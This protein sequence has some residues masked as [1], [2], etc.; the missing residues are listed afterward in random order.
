[1]I[2]FDAYEQEDVDK[3]KGYDFIICN[4]M[5]LR[6]SAEERDALQRL[7]SKGVPIIMHASTDSRNEMCSMDSIHCATISAYLSAGNMVNYQNMASYVRKYI[8]RK[9]FR[10]TDPEPP[11]ESI[12]EVFF[13]LEEGV[14]FFTIDEYDAYTRKKGLYKEGAKRVALVIGLHNPFRGNKQHLDSIIVSMRNAGHNVYPIFAKDKRLE[15]LKSANPDAVIYTAMGRLSMGEGD[16]VVEWLKETN[17]PLFTPLTSLELEEDWMAN[18]MG[19]V[20]GILGQGVVMPEIDGAVYPYALIAQEKNREGFYLFKTIPDRLR[21]FTDIVSRTIALKSKKNSEKK[22]AIYFFKGAGQQTLLAQSLETIPSLHN[23]L[24]R[25]RA[26]GYKVENL[27]ETPEELGRMLMSQGVILDPYAEGVQQEFLQKGN[28]ALIKKS[29]YEEW[30]KSSIFPEKY[31]EVTDLY[32][33]APGSYMS[34]EADGEPAIAVARLD[35]GNVALLPQPMAAVGDDAFAIVHGAK[36]PPPHPYIASYLWM[37]HGFKADAVLHFGTHG[38]LEF[39]PEK[40]VALSSADWS[41]RLIGSVPHFYYYTIAN[42]GECII[43]KRR[44]YAAITSYLMPP[45]MESNTRG[46]LADLQGKI[47]A[48]FKSPDPKDKASIAVKESAM[49]LGIHRYLRLDSIPAKPYTQEEIE[50]IDN[51]AEE[52][53]NE[54]V[55]GEL[56]ITGVPYSKEKVLTTVMA[57]SADPIAYSIARIDRLSGKVDTEKLRSNVYF[58]E[59]YLAPAKSVVRQ[60]LSGRA[61]DSL[62]VSSV[63]GV[64]PAEIREAHTLLAPPKRAMGGGR[65]PKEVRQH[66]K[67]EREKAFAIV[68]A[69]RTLYDVTKYK[70][71]LEESPEAELKGVLNALAGGYN[72]PS[73]GG[74]AIANPSA[75]PTGRN[76]Y[77]VNAEATPTEKAWEDGISLVNATLARY[78]KQHGDYPRKVSF[79]FWSGEFIE[80]EGTTIAQAL[81][82]LGVEPVRDSHGRVTDLRLI[83]ASELGRP[84]IDIVVQ[85]SGQFR[86]LAASRLMYI[87]RAVEM[88]AEA[89]DEGYE[90]KVKSSSVEVERLLVEQ[91]V[92][93]QEARELSTKRV[94]GGLNGMYGTKIKE[95]IASSDRW[96]SDEEIANAYINNMGAMYGTE[97]EWGAFNEHLFRAVLH[98]ADLVVQPRQNNTWGALSLDHVYEFMGGINAAIRSV[99]GKDPDAVFAD[100]RNRNNIRIQELKEAIGVEARATILNPNFVKETLKGGASSAQGVLDVVSNTFGWSA[101]KPD[102][103]DNE[104]WDEMYEMYV[105][106]VHNLGTNEFFKEINPASF[107]EITAI[108]LESSRK[109]MWKASPDKVAHLAELHAGLVKEF[110]STGSGFSATNPKLQEY[111]AQ[112]LRPDE[113]KSYNNA[114]SK[115]KNAAAVPEADKESVRLQRENLTHSHLSDTKT[116][117]TN[118]IVI[119]IGAILLFF[120]ILVVIKKRRR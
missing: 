86:D 119:A 44:T 56:Y 97:E 35:F 95:V 16:E 113:A 92:S 111:I 75:V 102:V 39:T 70:N 46:Q 91:G 76:L 1:M 115:M 78:K 77:S 116:I 98:D 21:T 59:H 58:T 106:D 104:L 57:M 80:S 28:P 3:L 2:H 42:I 65:M 52:I 41:D 84:R 74:D 117:L 100:Y 103:I 37:Q 5:G 36:S 79:T 50:Q 20:G 22:L 60:I 67:E 85:T 12:E 120:F 47:R 81:Y 31:K 30:V 64:S 38:S 66:T 112:Q 6:L 54:K 114:L 23:L 118:S 13:D 62:F 55:N 48:Y 68:E 90:N 24:L 34:T 32:G 4:G 93:P 14:H 18:P 8:D 72:A 82:M 11:T 49:A 110:G 25:L 9:S 94:F 89:K 107:Q 40:Q 83:P 33:E 61:V 108:M 88:A 109:G 105:K 101:T 19:L 51:F 69:E 96:S 45:F 17:I 73:S 10:V 15:M 63:I 43:A 87:T 71:A 26:E 99:T 53:A 27:P 29:L 7:A